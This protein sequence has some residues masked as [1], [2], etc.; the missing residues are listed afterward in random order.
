MKDLM[1]DTGVQT[2]TVHTND[3]ER[4]H[5]LICSLAATIASGIEANPSGPHADDVTA[6]RSLRIAAL[7]FMS[8]KQA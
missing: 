8:V 3:P 4:D 5:A 6:A 2:I 1:I 7:I